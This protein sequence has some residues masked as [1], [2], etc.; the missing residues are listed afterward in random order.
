MPEA[1]SQR[2]R[3]R[4]EVVRRVSC[5]VSA[6]ASAWLGRL[7]WVF[8]PMPD[9]VLY[10]RLHTSIAASGHSCTGIWSIRAPIDRAFFCGRPDRLSPLV[11]FA[12]MLR[13]LRYQSRLA[14]LR[15]SSPLAAALVC[16]CGLDVGMCFARSPMSPLNIAQRCHIH[17]AGAFLVM[18]SDLGA[19]GLRPC[20]VG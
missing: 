5:M 1:H 10:M 8:R 18:A 14:M 12:P 16:R 13:G 17:I 6:R 2:T 20:C 9:A 3:R 4:S 11:E 7:P 15:W 19:P